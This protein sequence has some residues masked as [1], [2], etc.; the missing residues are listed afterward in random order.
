[1]RSKVILRF[2]GFH[3]ECCSINDAFCFLFDTILVSKYLWVFGVFFSFWM[4]DLM[5]FVTDF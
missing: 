1:M 5:Y 4:L 2:S 3:A